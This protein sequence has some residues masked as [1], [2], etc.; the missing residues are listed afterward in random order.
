ML[1]AM[2]TLPGNLGH[3][4]V[5]V[6]FV[7]ALA[8]ALAYYQAYYGQEANRLSWH[9]FARQAFYLHSFAV[10]AV[11][12]VLFYIIYAHLYEYH[13]AWSHSSNNLPVYYMI[14]CFW[15]GQEGSFL[16]WTFWHVCL[17]LL[18]MHTARSWE[19]PVMAVFALVQAFL[20]SMILGV[21]FFGDFK[22][23][24]SPF[25]LLKEAMP[26]TPI[27]RADPD[28]VPKDG[29]GLNPLLQNYWMVIHP[30]TLF[31]GFAAT[32]VPFAFAIAGLQMKKYREWVKPALPWALFS[33]LILGLGIMM[34]GYWAYETLNFG[35]YWNWD[36][37]E[38]AV[39]VPW[40][41]L[42]AAI[43]VMIVF[44]RS[45]TALK[46]SFVLVIASFL[47]I[48]YSTFLTRSGILG[49]A[50]VHS[51]TDLGLSGQLLLYMFAFIALAAWYLARAWAHIPTADEEI[52]TYSREFWIFMGATVLCLA[53]FQ[54]IVGT[55]IPVYNKIIELFGGV[56]KMAPP[57]D[58][59]AF[60]NK[61]QLWA[62]VL[63]ALLSGTGQFFFWRKMDKAN[64]MNALTFPIA[65]TL[66]ASAAIIVLASVR[67]WK[68]MVLLTAA[69]Y[70]VMSNMAILVKL[71]KTTNVRIAGG[72][73]AHIGMAL[74]LLGIL[75]S[76]GYSKVVSLNSSGLLYNRDFS[77]EMN[78]E[79]LLLFR[80][81]AAKMA[82]YS[83]TYKGQRMESRD[84]PG[85][86]DREVLLPT[87]KPERM[88]ADAD[89]VHEGQTY[90][91]K[92]DTIQVYNE[93][94]FYEI[95]YKKPD[96]RVFTL[97]PRVQTNPQ[98]GTVVSPD[99]SHNVN[100]DLYTHVTMIPDEEKERKWSEAEKATL[101][102]G[103]TFIVNDYIAILDDVKRG[104][105][106]EDEDMNVFANIR[107]L[108]RDKVYEA[109]P[110][111][112]I[113]GNM[114]RKVPYVNTDLG[115]KITLEMINPETKD[116]TFTTQSSQKDWVILKAMEKP[117][118]NVMW[119]GVLIVLLGMGIA[120]ARRY[121]DFKTEQ[122]K[123][124]ATTSTK[125]SI[126]SV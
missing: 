34:G 37:V 89:L 1:V 126:P 46:A 5:V 119:L 84:F 114:V 17:G 16:L 61:F 63:V 70:S 53:G 103:D 105:L 81:Q 124:A 79:N 38:N 100:S 26:D 40:L 29:N 97:Y 121:Q 91:T 42:V 27:F 90:F 112:M 22:V 20:A 2:N 24:S 12:A 118:I 75:A 69:L 56:S 25:L 18:L 36:P 71:L 32:L 48:L 117:F 51:F 3:L 28:F 50:S 123:Q 8:A 58:P 92:G 73:V 106:I 60:Y 107:L 23:G 125:H 15:E 87:A 52:S 65:L 76:A 72:S 110:V 116:F 86:I 80:N 7:S 11:V 120:T 109:K 39:Y 41:I 99:I 67:E 14:S 30:P 64:L 78:K 49:N 104:Q 4:A 77:D 93:N 102:I 59:I 44:Q 62:A 33:A 113:K 9:R 96:G 74:M 88:V 94:V 19:L 111:F 45:N 85:Y 13:Y 122:A 95:E 57:A 68:Y 98:M 31:L 10:V 21:V 115:V 66:L 108:E 43:H 54:V 101:A 6:A 47:L 82:G 55:S 35:G 83:L